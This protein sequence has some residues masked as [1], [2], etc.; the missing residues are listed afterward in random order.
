MN[1][2]ESTPAPLTGYEVEIVA[3]AIPQCVMTVDVEEWFDANFASMPSLDR[4]RLP[5]CVE[6]GVDTLL[7]CF[8]DHGVRATFFVLGAIAERHRGLVGRIAAAGHEIGCH[9]YEHALIYSQSP[10]VLRE[11]LRITRAALCEQSNQ[12]VAGF[13][14]PSWSITARSL[15][16]LDCVAEAGFGYDSSIFPGANYLYGVDL[17]PERPYT[18]RTPSGRTLVEVPP[19]LCKWGRW[20]IGVG[21]GFYLRALPMWL[22]LRVMRRYLRTGIPFLAYVHPREVDP[23]AWRLRLP[24]AWHEQV[25]HRFRLRAT[26]AKLR[27]L[28]AAGRWQPLAEVLTNAGLLPVER[29]R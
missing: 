27:A 21:G 19:P 15:W 14:A 23:A 22:H 24:L 5:S 20:S 29:A 3:Q 28:L 26:P 17:A 6:A 11:Q 7:Q 13:R 9:G 25:I 2:G 12:A 18:I 10:A 16:A 8:A 4:S 1:R